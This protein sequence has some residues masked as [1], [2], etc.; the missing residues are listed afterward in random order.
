VTALRAPIGR[1]LRK[2]RSEAVEA[3]KEYRYG[4]TLGAPRR[5]GGK[6][7]KKTP[8]LLVPRDVEIPKF[9]AQCLCYF[10]SWHTVHETTNSEVVEVGG[11]HVEILAID[12]VISDNVIET[13]SLRRR[14]LLPKWL[15]FGL[16]YSLTKIEIDHFLVPA[17]H[18]L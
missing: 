4:M 17:S 13:P 14:N 10:A 16:A 9:L 15:I 2:T 7:G 5:K 11:R 8:S 3:L 1:F 12:H 6:K 18:L